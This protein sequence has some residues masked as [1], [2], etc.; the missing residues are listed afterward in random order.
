MRV[1]DFSS[2]DELKNAIV[3]AC[4]THEREVAEFDEHEPLASDDE[5]RR[6]VELYFTALAADQSDVD[7]SLDYLITDIPQH[8][9]DW[10]NSHDVADE[11]WQDKQ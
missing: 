11:D 4:M 10:K 2:M 7:L 8:I 9:I 5:I 1:R 6:I 3:T